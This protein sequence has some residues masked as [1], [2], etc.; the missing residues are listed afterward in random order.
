MIP[1]YLMM[2]GTCRLMPREIVP[3]AKDYG[4][5]PEQGRIRLGVKT[6]RAMRSLDTFRFT[7]P[8][9]GAIEA[10]AT[11]YGGTMKEWNEKR[12]TPQSQW[13]VITEATDIRVFLPQHSIDVWY[14]EWGGGGILRRCD[15]IDAQVEVKT[16][17]GTDI[18]IVPCH[19]SGLIEQGKQMMCRPYTRLSVILPEIRF[20]GTWR[21]ESKGWN[22]SKELPAMAQ[23][24]AQMQTIG[25]VE[26]RLSI[27]K[28][29]KI[30]GGQTRHFVVPKLS[31][32][33]SPLE[34]MAGGA[35]PQNVSLPEPEMP[36]IS[37]VKEVFP[38]IEVVDA[39]IVAAPGE[40]A[41]EE[42]WDKPPPGIAVKK[43][44]N[45]P[46]KYLKIND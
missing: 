23:V 29:T 9:P 3:I 39:V 26:G 24:I 18:D 21:L 13:E 30:S 6:E 46:P 38:D 2:K 16:P 19:C 41:W 7:S 5:I 40:D 8:D 28:R 25:I 42:G 12:A 10:I 37:T 43:N 4:R 22:A 44:P 27:E 14:E 17:D 35:R 45:P 33:T 32:D 1:N 34:I 15:G 31:M 11:L 36:A 20:G